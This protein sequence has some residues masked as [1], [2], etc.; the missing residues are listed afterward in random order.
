MGPGLLEFCAQLRSPF[1]E[2]SGQ[3]LRGMLQ[4]EG[5]NFACVTT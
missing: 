5:F 2:I 3:K 1:R 4:I